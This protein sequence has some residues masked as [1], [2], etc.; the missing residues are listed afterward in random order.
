MKNVFKN[1]S[2]KAKAYIIIS[3]FI[4]IMCFGFLMMKKEID[5]KDIEIIRED[6]QTS[7]FI[8]EREIERYSYI[9]E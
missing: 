6:V 3:L 9:E 1:L 8:D 7:E 2:D 5:K 4:P